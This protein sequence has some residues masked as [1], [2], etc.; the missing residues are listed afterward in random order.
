M[1]F[2]PPERFS[3]ADYFLDA[4]VAEGRGDRPA[5]L[6]GGGTLTYRGVQ[7]LANRFGHVLAAAGVQPEHR[8]ILALPDGPEYVGALFGTLKLGAVVVMLNPDLPAADVEYFLEYTRARAAVVHRDGAGPFL[9]AAGRRSSPASVLVVGDPAFEATLAAASP[10]LETFPT[11]RDDTAIWLFSGGTTGRPK[12]VLQSHASFANTTECYAKGVIGYHDADVTLSVPK[13]YFGYA[14]GSNLFFPFAAGGRAALF[15]EPSTAEALFRRIAEFRPTILINVPTMIN[16]MVSHPDA[17]HQDLS[18]LRV[19]TSAGEALPVELH[20]RWMDTFGVELLD[21]L[22]TAEMWHIFVSARPGA[23]RPGTLGTTVP[24]FEVRACD[25]E[26]REL[27]RG[28]TGWLWVRGHSRAIGYWQEMEKTARAFRG[29]W[30][31]SGDMIR[32]DADGYVTY[33]GR[34]DEMLKVSGKWLAPQEVESCL[35]QHPAVAEAAVVGVA[36]GHGLIKPRAFVVARQRDD[37]LADALKAFVR[38][39]LEPYKHPREVVFLDKLPRTHLGKVDRGALRRGSLV[40][41]SLA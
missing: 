29:E 12:A 10:A 5:L 24:G 1:P 16:K 36:D 20:R 11:H 30:Y 13:L 14:T 38:E 41:G 33:C 40:D 35:L 32:M 39:R 7:D 19:C 18:S 27:P 3:I 6:T 9:V 8:V 22:G 2:T 34:G 17:G 4:R 31:V 25:D 37:G 23:V 15:P 26:G 28:E 21:G